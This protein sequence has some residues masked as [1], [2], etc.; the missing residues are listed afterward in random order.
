MKKIKNLV[1]KFFLIDDTPHKVAAGAALGV[2]MG[3]FPG[4]GLAG[5]LLFSTILRFNRLSALSAVLATNMWS[6]IVALPMSAYVGALV[7]GKDYFRLISDFRE[8]Y[9]LSFSYFFGKLVFLDLTLP[10]LVGFMLTSSVI[11]LLIYF[12]LFFLLKKKKQ[13]HLLDN[14]TT[15]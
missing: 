14:N 3:I 13:T 7:F 5:A 12:I 15:L 6:T 10:V 9:N 4:E 2:F 8:N 1:K 11:A